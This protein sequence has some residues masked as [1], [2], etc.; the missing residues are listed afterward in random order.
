MARQRLSGEGDGVRLPQPPLP[1][2]AEDAFVLCPFGASPTASPLQ[3]LCQQAI[4][5][6]AL[7]Q[8]QA[9]AR[10]S[11]LERDLLGVWN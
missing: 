10:P 5:R 2:P 6:Y 8:A 9:V 1:T 3:W 4:Y 7:E 11:I